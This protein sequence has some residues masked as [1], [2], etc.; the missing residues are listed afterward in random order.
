[1]GSLHVQKGVF[2]R[3]VTRSNAGFL[4]FVTRS[5]KLFWALLHVQTVFVTHSNE[6]F[7]ALLHVQSDFVTYSS[8]SNSVQSKTRMPNIQ[9]GSDFL[10]RT[11]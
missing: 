11:R 5:N 1:M 3:F 9:A 10:F 4:S 8:V 2:L 7:Q 6:L